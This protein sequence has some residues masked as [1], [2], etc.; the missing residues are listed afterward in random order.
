[1]GIDAILAEAGRPGILPI[2]PIKHNPG[3]PASALTDQSSLDLALGYSSRAN[4]GK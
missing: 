3:F 4:T 2:T 1:M